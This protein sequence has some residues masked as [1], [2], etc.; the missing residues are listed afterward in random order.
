MKFFFSFFLQSLVPFTASSWLFSA[1]TFPLWTIIFFHFLIFFPVWWFRSD[2]T[3]WSLIR[4]PF[5]RLKHIF[6][7]FSYFL[8]L[9]EAI[10]LWWYFS[11][12]ARH[13]LAHIIHPLSSFQPVP[14][15]LI[16]PVF[17]IFT[18]QNKLIEWIL[19]IFFVAFFL[20]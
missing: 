10:Y 8:L 1:T 12:F 6:F 2:I 4:R 19:A 15:R 9:F 5:L 18:F 14:N 11:Y 7:F 13:T 17:Y 20:F 3:Y 16:F